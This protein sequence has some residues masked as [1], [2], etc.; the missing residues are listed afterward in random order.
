MCLVVEDFPEMLCL[1]DRVRE[2]RGQER[3]EPPR[4]FRER[5]DLDFFACDSEF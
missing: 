2:V 3:G 1:G 4:A 5:G